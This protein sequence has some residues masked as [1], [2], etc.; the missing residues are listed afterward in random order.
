MGGVEEM[1][2]NRIKD[3][4]VSDAVLDEIKRL[5]GSGE[6]KE[7]SKIP[8]ENEL[9][10]MMGVSRVSVRSALQKLSSLGVIESRHGDGTFICK[11]DGSQGINMLI[12]VAILTGENHKYMV[13]F[14]RIIESEEAYL[15]AIRATDEEI[16]LMK[17]NYKRMKQVD[18]MSDECSAL[19]VEFHLLIAQSCKNP[20]FIQTSNIL[21]PTIL[22]NILYAR[23]YTSE[24]Y[25]LKYHN[26][27]IEAIEKRDPVAARNAMW[28]HM[29]L[30]WDLIKNT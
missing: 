28:D 16:A 20:M 1:A 19:D 2:I 22:D 15:A 11:L 8:P 12:P 13:E 18:P 14:R 30:V 10:A 24:N 23:K 6:W 7:G 17:E 4:N 29:D 27:I 26:M 9:A 3:K 25:A 5:I 21:Q